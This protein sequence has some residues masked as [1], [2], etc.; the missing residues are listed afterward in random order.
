[1][2]RPDRLVTVGHA[3]AQGLDE[4]TVELGYGITDS[5][6]H[7]DGGST[8]FDHRLENATQVVD[9]A[10]VTVFRTELNVTHQ[11]TRETHRELG[12]LKHLLGRHAEFFLHVQR[13]GCNEGVYTRRARAFEGFGSAGDIAVIGARQRANRRILDGVGNR[14]HSI[15][16]A[17]GTGRK[18]GFDHVHLESLQLA[19]NAQFFIARHGGPG[20][21]LAIAQGGVENDQFIG[22]SMSSG[23]QKYKIGELQLWVSRLSQRLMVALDAADG[24][25]L[26]RGGKLGT[27]SKGLST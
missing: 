4:V 15:K 24:P 6:R 22:H 17:I 21:L 2:D 14:L 20:R 13:A 12:L 19:R 25:C 23:K 18:A 1:M 11:V 9:I 16:V 5:V 3:L 8:L 10:A 26:N 27:Y 7:V